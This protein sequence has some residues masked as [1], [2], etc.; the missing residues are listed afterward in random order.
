MALAILACDEAGL[1][2]APVGA[3]DDD[4]GVPMATAPE[5]LAGPWLELEPLTT[6]RTGFAAAV[7]GGAVILA[8]GTEGGAPTARASRYTPDA[9]EQALGDLA[10]PLTGSTA[11]ASSGVLVVVGGV[12][13]VAASGAT[14]A[15]T[16]CSRLVLL[17][18][19]WKPCAPVGGGPVTGAAAAYAGGEALLFGG[20][21]SIDPDKGAFATRVVQGYDLGLDRWAAE[22]ALPELRDGASAVVREGVAH[23]IGGRGLDESTGALTLPAAVLSYERA[24]Y[25]WRTDR[26]AALPTPRYGIACAAVGGAL[27]CAGGRDLAGQPLA[28]AERLDLATGVWTPLAPLPKPLAGARAVSLGGRLLVLGGRTSG[29][30]VSRSVFELR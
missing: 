28:A 11:V 10:T 15:S 27:Y 20:I 4:A 5:P 9:G 30:A 13:A 12:G 25:T 1:G 24:S 8:G 16:G 19:D 26:I 21:R 3:S 14:W 2:P 29:D 22:T 6:E 23:V 17:A 7:L 18:S